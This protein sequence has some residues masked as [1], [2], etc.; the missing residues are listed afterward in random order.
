MAGRTVSTLSDN[1]GSA[2]MA[3]TPSAIGR[4]APIVTA[5]TTEARPCPSPRWREPSKLTTAARR[6]SLPDTNST[7]TTVTTVRT[8][9]NLR[10]C[11]T[12]LRPGRNLRPVFVYA[13]CVLR[14]R[15]P[16]R[17]NESVAPRRLL[18]PSTNLCSEKKKGRL[19]ND[20]GCPPFFLVSV[21]T[22]LLASALPLSAR[23]KNSDQSKAAGRSSSFPS[24][25]C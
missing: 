21:A 25:G 23:K 14:N 19:P 18:A 10:A 5:P 15:D 17:R 24:A 16:F 20:E 3:I 13:G 12:E 4:P 7:A 1:R 2:V 9:G 11:C 22:S 6:A 8:A